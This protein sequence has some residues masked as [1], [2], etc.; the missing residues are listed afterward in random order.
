MQNHNNEWTD[1]YQTILYID[2]LITVISYMHT[3][4]YACVDVLPEDTLAS[5][6]L[7]SHITSIKVLTTMHAL[8]SYKANLSN[9]CLITYF[10][11]IWAL[12]SMYGCML[13]QTTL[14]TECLITHITNIRALISMYA[15]KSF[16]I[17]LYTECLIT[18]KYKGRHKYVC[19]VVLS[20]HYVD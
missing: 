9:E 13:Y 14:V 18:H 10:T 12:T 16:Q 8:I 2:R 1:L 15:L 5:E 3:Q 4:Q 11:A 19:V 7:I 20:D 6:C 17:G